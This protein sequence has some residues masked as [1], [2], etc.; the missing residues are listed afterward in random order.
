M[1]IFRYIT[2]GISACIT[3]IIIIKPSITFFKSRLNYHSPQLILVIGGDI[4]REIA[5][6]KV[7]KAIN[8]P[9]LISSSRNPEYSNWLR[10][11]EDVKSDL[12]R[13]DYSSNDTLSN[14]TSIIDKLHLEGVKHLLY[15]ISEDNRNQSRVASQI[16][17]GSKGI[18]LTTLAIPC[19]SYCQKEDKRKGNIDI[20]RSV[21]WVITGK[22]LKYLFPKISNGKFINN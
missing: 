13:I 9:V 21:A 5:G 7:A 11:N 17:A 20:L 8:L 3:W 22:D 2:I 1:K 6:L 4:D 19:G 10:E 16:I 12:L 14:F 18:M 15:I